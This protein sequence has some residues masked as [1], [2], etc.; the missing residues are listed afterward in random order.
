[1]MDAAIEMIT[2]V[3][4]KT[5]KKKSLNKQIFDAEAQKKP[6]V[7]QVIGNIKDDQPGARVLEHR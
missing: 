7:P 2:E 6:E 3:E 1:M 5:E 4:E